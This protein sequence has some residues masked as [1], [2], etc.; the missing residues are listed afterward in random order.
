MVKCTV[1]YVCILPMFRLIEL[2]GPKSKIAFCERER[3]VGGLCLGCTACTYVRRRVCSSF[4]QARFFSIKY[5]PRYCFLLTFSPETLIRQKRLIELSLNLEALLILN[6]G[7][8]E[9]LNTFHMTGRD[10]LCQ[11]SKLSSHHI[12]HRRLLYSFFLRTNIYF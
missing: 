9:G 3:N 4:H 12:T 2:H 5:F 6:W 1:G 7:E 11:K 8:K 10:V